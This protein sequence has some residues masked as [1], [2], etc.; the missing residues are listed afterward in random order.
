MLIH[1]KL[2]YLIGEYI[3]K[4][5]MASTLNNSTDS[6]SSASIS[7][8]TTSKPK[9]LTPIKTV[10]SSCGLTPSINCTTLQEPTISKADFEVYLFLNLSFI[11]KSIYFILN[12]SLKRKIIALEANQ[13][14]NSVQATVDL[15]FIKRIALFLIF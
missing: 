6:S 13:A 3:I 1:L 2:K 11:L 8:A 7:P 15:V 10:S 9:P 14:S 12:Q 4:D 5:I